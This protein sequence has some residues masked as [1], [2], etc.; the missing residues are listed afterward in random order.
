M[1]GRGKWWK[2][3]WR[4]GFDWVEG[5]GMSAA[6][7]V[8]VNSRFTRGVVEGVWGWLKQ[9][10]PEE[11]GVGVVYPCVHVEEGELEEGGKGGEG[12]KVLW[13]EKK[14]ILSIN[15]FERKKGIELAL[16]AFARMGEREKKGSRLVIAGWFFVLLLFS[17]YFE[18]KR[19]NSLTGGYDPRVSENV[20]YHQELEA[21][22]ESLELRHTT[23]KNM[24]TAQAAP[25]S[26]S[27]LFLLSVP[28]QLKSLLLRTAKLL[29]YTP[30]N[31][32]F[33][34]VPLEAMLT[35]VPVLAASSG[36]PLETVVE[37]ETGWLR[38]VDDVQ[39]WSDIIGD[40]VAGKISERELEMI[41]E[42]GRRR[43]R[44][45]FSEDK[46]ARRLDTE[47]EMMMQGRRRTMVGTSGILQ[48]I[49]V[50]SLIVIFVAIFIWR[51]LKSQTT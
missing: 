11:E 28:A 40:V 43:V 7:R 18:Q 44:K 32:H 46:M 25:E 50:F 38:Y 42:N 22:A 12:E 24:I 31:E 15:R 14:V 8:L 4:L 13:K 47:I 27:V 19:A 20:A 35:G 16:R 29:V 21:L 3:V 48:R 10:G 5:C 34:I 6:D 45:E 9:G 30:S 26:I 23:A 39:A 41:A 2:R 37:G 49:G 51:N 36:G 33:G 1:Q 17:P